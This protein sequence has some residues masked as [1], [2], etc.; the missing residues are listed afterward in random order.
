MGARACVYALHSIAFVSFSFRCPWVYCHAVH[1]FN[2]LAFC[3][4]SAPT[5]IAGLRRLSRTGSAISLMSI[6][7]AIPLIAGELFI[8]PLNTTQDTK[9]GKW[10]LQQMYN[11]VLVTPTPPHLHHHRTY[12]T[13][14][15]TATS[16]HAVRLSVF[17]CVCLCVFVCMV[18]CARVYVWLCESLPRCSC[19]NQCGRTLV[20]HPLPAC[21]S[22]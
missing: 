4:V 1:A 3:V 20:A 18:M 9:Y 13:T 16:P 17:V 8:P 15:I 14:A 6:G 11:A 21:P 7:F 5:A 19:A 10:A 12:T 22:S 2:R